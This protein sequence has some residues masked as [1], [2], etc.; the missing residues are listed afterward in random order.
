[1]PS[2]F[3]QTK[4]HKEMFISFQLMLVPSLLTGRCFLPGAAHKVRTL[5]QPVCFSRLQ[6]LLHLL[7]D[8]LNPCS[9]QQNI[10]GKIHL[11]HSYVT[12]QRFELRIRLLL[13]PPIPSIGIQLLT[14][15]SSASILSCSA[16]C[17]PILTVEIIQ[18]ATVS[19]E[20]FLWTQNV[21]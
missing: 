15:F 4:W 20:Q 13:Q 14:S 16:F 5:F 2:N 8:L 18:S 7:A 9:V 3:I 1:M 11:V 19:G 10:A 6:F 17:F 12:T 21:S